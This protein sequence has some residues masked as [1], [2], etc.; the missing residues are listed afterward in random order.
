[1]A[2]TDCSVASSSNRDYHLNEGQVMGSPDSEGKLVEKITERLR[3]VDLVHDSS[4]DEME[5]SFESLT[6]E[7]CNNKKTPPKLRI[8]T[9]CATYICANNP[10]AALQPNC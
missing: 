4:L 7:V 2:M 9:Y 8:T 3:E 10:F 5:H 6:E 1:M